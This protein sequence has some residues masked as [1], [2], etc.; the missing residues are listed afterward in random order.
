MLSHPQVPSA[1]GRYTS[2]DTV[3]ELLRWVA[4]SASPTPDPLVAEP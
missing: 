3:V 4:A 2:F 1:T